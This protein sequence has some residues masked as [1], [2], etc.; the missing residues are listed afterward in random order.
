MFLIAGLVDISLI[1]GGA[2]GSSG[3]DSEGEGSVAIGSAINSRFP[4]FFFG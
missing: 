4:S 1:C 3:T 2:E